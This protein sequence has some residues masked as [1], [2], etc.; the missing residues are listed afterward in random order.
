MQNMFFWHFCSAKKEKVKNILN[1][2]NIKNTK[3]MLHN[4]ATSGIEHVIIHMIGWTN[5][6]L[7]NSWACSNIFIYMTLCTAL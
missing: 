5:W 1:I 4:Q 3:N 2:K 7:S 6:R